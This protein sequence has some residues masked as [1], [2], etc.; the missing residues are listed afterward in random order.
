V[1]YKNGFVIKVNIYASGLERF[2]ILANVK[3]WGRP[4]FVIWNY[5]TQS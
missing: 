2:V 3:G 4:A 1:F 5:V